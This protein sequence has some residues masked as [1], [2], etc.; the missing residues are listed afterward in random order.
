MHCSLLRETC[1]QCEPGVVGG[2]SLEEQEQEEE[3]RKQEV[4]EVLGKGGSRRAGVRRLKRKYGLEGAGGVGGGSLGE[5]YCDRAEVR[6]GIGFLTQ[7]S[8]IK[9]L[10]RFLEKLLI[11][12]KILDF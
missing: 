8:D 1:L 10:E 2:Q 3:R 4:Q 5:E 6:R 7:I 12:I 11:Y 9:N